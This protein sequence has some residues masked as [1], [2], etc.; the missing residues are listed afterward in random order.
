[1]KGIVAQAV[2]QGRNSTCKVKDKAEGQDR[3]QTGYDIKGQFNVNARDQYIEIARVCNKSLL[4][5]RPKSH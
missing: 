5:I 4:K 2:G 3:Q 1:M